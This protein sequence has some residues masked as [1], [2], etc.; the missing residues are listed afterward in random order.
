MILSNGYMYRIGIPSG[1]TQQL[2]DFFNFGQMLK[3]QIIIKMVKFVLFFP[4]IIVLGCNKFEDEKISLLRKE[5]TGNELRIDGYYYYNNPYDAERIVVFVLYN[6]GIIR[7]CGSLSSFQDFENLIN[8]YNKGSSTK[9]QWGVFIVEDNFIKYEK[10]YGARFLE[11]YITYIY[12]GKILNDT[13]FHI[14]ERYRPNGKERSTED[15]LFHFKQFSP[16]PDS[17]NKFIP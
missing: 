17:T 13:T 2:C 1:L 12:E 6:N 9:N 4:L 11:P 3:K 7:A 8:A 10:W 14:K 5:Y 15:L 16:K